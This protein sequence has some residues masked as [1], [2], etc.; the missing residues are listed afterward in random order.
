MASSYTIRIQG[1]ICRRSNN[2]QTVDKSKGGQSQQPATEKKVEKTINKRL[3]RTQAQVNEVVDI[4]RVNIEKVLE[5]DKNLSQLDDR[6]GELLKSYFSSLTI[7][8]IV[9]VIFH[10]LIRSTNNH[11]VLFGGGP[12][13]IQAWHDLRRNQCSHWDI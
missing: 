6:A 10:F 8:K 9:S 7:L 5:R 2:D 12:I 13:F 1:R 11:K 3:Q 4:M